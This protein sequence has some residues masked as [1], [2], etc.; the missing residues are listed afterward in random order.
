MK[1]DVIALFDKISG[2]YHPPMFV[3]SIPA[4]VRDL[5]EIINTNPQ[6][7]QEKPVWARHPS[8]FDLYLVCYWDNESGK[9]IIDSEAGE[10]QVNLGTLKSV[11]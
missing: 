5:Q 8:D 11:S 1:L 4:A 6:P 9:M 7:G 2:T 3:P 10:F